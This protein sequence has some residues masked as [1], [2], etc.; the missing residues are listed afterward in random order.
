MESKS[1]L[2]VY[3]PFFLALAVIFGLVIGVRLAPLYNTSGAGSGSYH[4]K[5]KLN[6]ILD[7]IESDYVDTIPVDELEENTIEK[8]LENLDP[9]SQYIKAS[10][11]AEMN[12]PL[13]GSFE[14]IGVQFRI[15]K[16]TVV[17]IQPIEGGPSASVGI[18]AGDRI[19]KVD[20]QPITGKKIT[21][22]DVMRKLKGKRGT[23]VK[24]SIF[25]RGSA[26]L[27]DFTITRDV[28]PTYSLDIAYM[29]TDDIG[30]VKLNNFSATTNDE[31]SK[32]LTDLKALGL[33]KLILDLRNNS[34]GYLKSA[35][36]LCD[37]FLT[38]KTL[39]VYTEG[40][41]RPKSFTYA[42]SKGD[43]EDDPLVILIDEGSASASEITAGAI[44][45]N[46]RG[47]VIG[48]RSFGKGLVQEQLNLTDGSALRLTVARY[49][50]PSG[51]SIQ[52]SYKNGKEIYYN[53]FHERLMNGE[54][55]NADSI[56][57]PDSL[58]YKTNKGR[59][60]YG[61][62]GIMPDYFVPL[63]SGEKF[64][65]YNQLL[66]K[67]VMIDYA[68]DYTDL[69]RKDLK[70]FTDYKQF[71]LNFG[72]TDQMFA[73]LL[74]YADKAGIERDEKSLAAG[75]TEIIQLVKALIGRNL[76]DNKGFY[77]ILNKTDKTVQKAI[78]ILN[79]TSGR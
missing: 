28:I 55:Q 77:P 53:D 23:K 19:V 61:G 27:R 73:D 3:L 16:D 78:E 40:K 76:F 44:Q 63:E 24:V 36:D 56:H 47:A 62:G 37:E 52:R 30:Y 38:D 18:L 69:N 32:A 8:V 64:R 42:T 60:V 5:S 17:I 51:R 21:N 74:K 41:N 9:H 26:S 67:G 33:Q 34:G 4:N 43:F 48:R 65:Y 46:D 70:R 29:I 10:E 31:F 14:G 66:N 1:R 2:K 6:T 71:D 50:T 72:L 68:F 75:K 39:I 20:G 13:L 57:F 59:T 7:F 45:D 12:D 49:Y 22:A 15:E 54:L 79:K 25:R 11:F 58:K 35:T